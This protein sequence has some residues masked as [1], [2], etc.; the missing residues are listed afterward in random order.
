[1]ESI[2]SRP[3]FTSI[4]QGGGDIFTPLAGS[5]Y[6]YGILEERSKHVEALRAAATAVKFL[7]IDEISLYEIKVG[8]GEIGSFNLRNQDHFHNLF[9]SL[10]CNSIYIDIT[11]L[12]HHVWAPLLRTALDFGLTV[13]AVYVEPLDY[14]YSPSPRQGAIFDLSERIEG[15]SPIPLFTTLLRAREQDVCF[16]P[17]LGFEGARLAHMIDQVEPPG[18]KI[19]PIVGVPGFRA[20]YPFHAYLGNVADLRETGAWKNVRFAK[21][22]C[23]F[24]LFYV[25]DDVFDRYAE[26]HIK[27]APIG[28]KPHAL[29]AVLKSIHSKRPVELIYD[30]PKRKEGRTSGMYHCLVY[31]VSEFIR[32]VQ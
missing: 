1:M 15:I 7:N 28:T 4:F 17:L 26:E 19:V 16:V 24:S 30:H 25:L 5:V 8:T 6:F 21:A 22:N 29:G 20:E 14:H 23:P 10:A 3:L 27:I 18:Q 13:R 32:G 9:R 31:D 2:A 11:G 12:G